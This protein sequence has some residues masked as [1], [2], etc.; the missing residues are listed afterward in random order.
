M[1]IRYVEE[2]PSTQL[3]LCD[4]VRAGRIAP[5][6]A[7]IA[8]HQSVGIGSR[9]NRWEGRNR[10]LTFSFALSLKSLP[11]DL[12][13]VSA[14]IYFGYHFKRIL[15][16][17]G[18]KV[19]LKWPNDLYL[20][21]KKLGGVLTSKIGE[22]LV[23]GIGANLT[24]P[25]EIYGALE[26]EISWNGVIEEFLSEIEQPWEWKPTFNKYKIEFELSSDFVFHYK[27]ERVHAGE[28]LLC[29]DGALLLRGEKIY[30][31]R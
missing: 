15:E 19:W 31:A 29:D 6:F 11:S 28:A 1:E 2:L 21:D 23:V 20:G 25:S 27:G 8:K 17:R 16:R 12:P 14:S 26:P 24:A 4:E 3:W 7:I 30:S 9:G 13:I 18:S 5:P 10:A 22:A